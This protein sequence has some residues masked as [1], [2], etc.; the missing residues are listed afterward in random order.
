MRA[1]QADDCSSVQVDDCS[2]VRAD[3]CSSL[4]V[5][6]CSAVWVDDCSAVQVDDCSSLQT[7]Q[8]V[9]ASRTWR[10]QAMTRSDSSRWGYK[11]AEERACAPLLGGM[12]S[13]GALNQVYSP[14]SGTRSCSS[15]GIDLRPCLLCGTH[16]HTCNS[17]SCLEGRNRFRSTAN[18]ADGR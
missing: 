2:A 9:R 3:D 6:D 7:V 16:K 18:T 11:R 17:R 12:R 14:T 13:G 5:D 8:A 15:R 10:A 4:Q 1:V